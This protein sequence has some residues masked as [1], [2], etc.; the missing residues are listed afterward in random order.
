M[1]PMQLDCFI[2]TLIYVY[3]NRYYFRLVHKSFCITQYVFIVMQ[4]KLVV[5]V[6]V[7]VVVDNKQNL[8][9]RPHHF[10]LH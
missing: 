10:L 2:I 7:V 6:V 1:Q 8:L 3:D 4:I 9:A 5:V